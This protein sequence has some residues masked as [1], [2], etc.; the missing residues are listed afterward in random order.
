MRFFAAVI[1]AVATLS[2]ASSFAQT[3]PNKPIRII[4]P[5]AP[6]GVVD[7]V[8][9]MVAARLEAQLGI[10]VVV[11]NRTGAGTQ[12]GTEY[13]TRAAP[14]GYTLLVIDPSVAITPALRPDANY[15]L[16]Q[17]KA[18]AT[19]TTAPLM[20]VV[21]SSLPIH[22]LADLVEYS[23]KQ[24][25]GITYAS[26]G[27]GTTPHLAPELLKV[28]YGFRAKQVPY[29]G[30]GPSIPDLVAGRVTTAFYSNATV[31]PMI[32][33]GTLRAVA[34]TG[35]RRIEATPNVPT[36]METGFPDFNVELWTGIFAP[37]GI[38]ADVEQRL[39]A[40]LK[41]MAESPEFLALVKKAGLELF[42]KDAATAEKFVLLE[43][44]RWGGVIKAANIIAP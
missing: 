14:D 34:Q 9:R 40:E 5:S 3:Y 24:P 17:L 4:S 35:A 12:V 32:Q 16:K 2:G 37:A 8:S 1:F 36:A 25:E 27:V 15:Q 33:A 11:E 22:S 30:G 20:V 31:L 13:V 43:N 6:G 10:S 39:G 18:L 29:A 28:R 38:P 7:T 41:K 42:Y 19:L 44:E 26:P 21:N 23:K